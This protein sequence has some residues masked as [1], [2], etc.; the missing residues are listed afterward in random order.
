MS[1]SIKAEP[2][3]LIPFKLY[4]KLLSDSRELLRARHIKE[5]STTFNPATAEGKGEED[6]TIWDSSTQF[7][8]KQKKIN[9]FPG[10]PPAV[11]FSARPNP[12]NLQDVA[13]PQSP[14]SQNNKKLKTPHE[15][16]DK[17][18]WFLKDLVHD[19]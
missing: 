3:V 18:W 8:D 19:N 12:E 7:V 15:I 6:L 11:P 9:E 17:P 13:N 16:G 2:K 14:Q 5:K 4:Q 1:K 10:D